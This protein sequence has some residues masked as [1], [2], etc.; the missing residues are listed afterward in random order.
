[1]KNQTSKE[2][3]KEL[4]KR[5]EGDKDLERVLEDF[6]ATDKRLE[7]ANGTEDAAYPAP[8]SNPRLRT[9]KSSWR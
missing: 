2:R 9:P 6:D 3:W 7:S 4:V 1:M 5:V 8:Y